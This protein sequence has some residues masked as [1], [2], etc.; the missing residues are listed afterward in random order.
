MV[1]YDDFAWDRWIYPLE[2]SRKLFVIEAMTQSESPL[3]YPNKKRMMIVYT[4]W[5][6]P[7]D[8]SWFINPMNTVVI[9]V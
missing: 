8:V 4:M 3:I 2:S 7:S 5:W 1:T 9:Y 6:P